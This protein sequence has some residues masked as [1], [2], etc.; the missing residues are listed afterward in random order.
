LLVLLLICSSA[1]FAIQTQQHHVRRMMK[2]RILSKGQVHTMIAE[3]KDEP[4][5]EHHHDEHHHEEHHHEAAPETPAVTPAVENTEATGDI[6]TEVAKVDEKVEDLIAIVKQDEVSE[7]PL[8]APTTEEQA[9]ADIASVEA[10][11]TEEK[12]H[13]AL[14]EATEEKIDKEM[15]HVEADEQRIIEEILSNTLTPDQ[16]KADQEE[17]KKDAALETNL[18]TEEHEIQAAVTTTENKIAEED[19]QLADD[20]TIKTKEGESAQMETEMDFMKKEI[21]NL[22]NHDQHIDKEENRLEAEINHG[23][24]ESQE[25]GAQEAGAQEAG[26]QEVAQEAEARAHEAEAQAAHDQ[27]IA[28]HD[29]QVAA[30]EASVP[31][32]STP[33]SDSTGEH[34]HHEEHHHDEH[35]HEE[36][37]HDEHHHEEH[38]KE[39]EK[40]T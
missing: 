39:H 22:E 1:V 21:E 26:A 4:E 7:A 27:E 37:N 17:L 31:I 38:E 29:Q 35:N 15:T 25:A 13:E 3:H 32:E 10:E 34:H 16:L 12:G 40:R 18:E 6:A 24:P 14:L 19:L 5:G 2:A 28:A 20:E 8:Q 36:H 33:P 30:Q 23:A 11:I 9:K